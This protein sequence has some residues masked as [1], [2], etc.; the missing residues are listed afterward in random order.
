MKKLLFIII[1][2]LLCQSDSNA[3]DGNL[4]GFVLGGGF[5]YS[6][7]TSWNIKNINLKETFDPLII[8][9]RI[10]HGINKSNLIVVDV[11]YSFG[12]RTKKLLDTKT[13]FWVNGIRWF[14][15]F[16]SN[17]YNFN[18]SLGISILNFKTDFCNIGGH[19]LGLILGT[20]VQVM[21]HIQFDISY[22]YGNTSSSDDYD[23]NHRML[24]FTLTALAY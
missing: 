23:N 15:Y 13:Y 21:K 18:Y 6:P 8:S 14:H 16:N 22:V 3:F 5:G 4:K 19:G 1:I 11:F 10:G 2:F 24:A 7:H 20:G 12:Y 17:K 9:G